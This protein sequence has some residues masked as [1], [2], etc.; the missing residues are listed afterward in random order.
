[1]NLPGLLNIIEQCET[2]E[3]LSAKQNYMASDVGSVASKRVIYTMA[4]KPIST[5]NGA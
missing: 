2:A 4:K 5:L 3:T 1:M